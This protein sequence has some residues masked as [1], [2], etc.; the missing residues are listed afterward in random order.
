M[1]AS[2]TGRAPACRRAS[3][4]S[5]VSIFP[6]GG[7]PELRDRLLPAGERTC[8]EDARSGLY[9]AAVL[10]EGRLEAVLYLSPGPTLPSLEWLKGQFARAAIPPA[11]RRAL[12]A[13]RALDGA[14]DEGPIV[15]VCHQVGRK[16]IEAAIAAG[17][18]SA[19][20][21]GDGRAGTNC[22]SCVP[23]LKRLLD[24]GRAPVQ[25]SFPPPTL[26]SRPASRT[27]D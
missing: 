17:A 19:D 23:E 14:A 4:R 18:T 20:A 10:R 24:R 11:E 1:T 15:C 21:I 27:V 9:R 22:G 12:L 26:P 2:P 25:G 5:S 3:S 8:Y 16:R 13:G 7:W 6:A